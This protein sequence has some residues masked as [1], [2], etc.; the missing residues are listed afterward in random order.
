MEGGRTSALEVGAP[1]VVEVGAP[2]FLD[3]DF[4][5]LLKGEALALVC[6]SA[7]LVRGASSGGRTT[8]A[9]GGSSVALKRSGRSGKVMPYFSSKYPCIPSMSSLTE[10]KASRFISYVCPL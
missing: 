7:G 2:A 1:A 10:G 8:V 5:A 4:L 3:E 9:R 6:I